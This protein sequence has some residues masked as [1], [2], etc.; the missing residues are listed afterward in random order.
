[1]LNLIF[2]KF[3]LLIE[4]MTVLSSFYL[5]C[6]TIWRPYTLMIHNFAIIFNQVTMVLF[7]LLQLVMKYKLANSM[8]E[9]IGLYLTLTLISTALIIQAIRLYMHSLSLK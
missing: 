9:T 7:V 3:Q 1:M 5:I 4:A 6:I 2:E 8:L